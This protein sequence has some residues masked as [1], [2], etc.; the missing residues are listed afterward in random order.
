[1]KESAAFEFEG[2]RLGKADILTQRRGFLKY[3][4]FI[5]RLGDFFGFFGALKK[6]ADTQKSRRRN[7]LCRV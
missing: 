6:G 5:L 4:G 1:V 3:L 2:R 7:F